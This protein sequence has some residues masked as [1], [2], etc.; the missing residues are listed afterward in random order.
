MLSLIVAKQVAIMF[1]LIG[2]GFVLTKFDKLNDTGAKFFTNILLMAVTPAVLINAYQRPFEVRL[3][4][5]LVMGAVLTLIIHIVAILLC[6]VVFRREDT[7][8]YRVARFGAVYSNC[9][10][11]AIP[12]LSATLGSEGVFY[13]SSYLATFTIIYW[14]LGVYTLTENKKDLSL[15]SIFINPG[16]IGSVI[17]ISLFVFGVKLP[18]LVSDC[19]D[20]LAAMNTPLSMIVLGTYL[21]KIRL[22]ETFKNKLLYMAVGMRLFI[23]PVI[24]W[25][26]MMVYPINDIAGKAILIAAGCPAAAVTSLFASN[27]GLDATF[28]SEIVSVSTLLSIVSI[29]LIVLLV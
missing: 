24:T 18:P 7:L 6:M 16:I 9:G 3:A 25:L 14:T 29:P 12:L 2:V 8:R 15:K 22:S 4:K 17:A 5:E 20:D 23:I 27:Y 28:G 21:A 26:I 13:G 1:L 11:M 19:V 10:F